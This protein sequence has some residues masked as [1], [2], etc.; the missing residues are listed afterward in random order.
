[1][2][3]RPRHHHRPDDVPYYPDDPSGP[4]HKGV[5][6]GD[7]DRGSDQHRPERRVSLHRVK[8][9]CVTPNRND[10]HSGLSAPYHGSPPHTPLIPSRLDDQDSLSRR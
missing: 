5:T 7:H 8:T 6:P 3:H 2:V 10:M 9:K 1:M 4:V